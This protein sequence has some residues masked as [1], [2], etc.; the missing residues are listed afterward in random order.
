LQNFLGGFSAPH[1]AQSDAVEFRGSLLIKRGKGDAVAVRSNRCCSSSAFGLGTEVAGVTSD[2]ARRP[3]SPPRLLG[4]A[5]LV[6]GFRPAGA[7]ER[8]WRRRSGRCPAPGRA[9]RR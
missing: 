4:A 7:R 9:R 2:Y 5:P 3:G 1:D 6:R 8:R